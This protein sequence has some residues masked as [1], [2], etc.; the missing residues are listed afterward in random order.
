MFFFCF[1][2]WKRTDVCAFWVE[3]VQIGLM[4][5]GFDEENDVDIRGCM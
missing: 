3:L 4:G 5:L 2:F 1:F